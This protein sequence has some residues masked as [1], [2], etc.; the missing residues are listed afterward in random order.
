MLNGVPFFCELLFADLSLVFTGKR[1]SQGCT[2]THAYCKVINS[3]T[4]AGA[5]GYTNTKKN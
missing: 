5:N 3:N 1:Q 2:Y 4:Y